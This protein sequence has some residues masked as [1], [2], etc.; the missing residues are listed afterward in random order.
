MNCRSTEDLLLN[1]AVRTKLMASADGGEEGASGERVMDYPVRREG[2][3]C[4]MA[5]IDARQCRLWLYAAGIDAWSGVEW[6]G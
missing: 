6:N 2:D 4:S 3:S 5:V 1:R